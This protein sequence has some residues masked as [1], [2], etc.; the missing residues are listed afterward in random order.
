MLLSGLANE[1]VHRVLAECYILLLGGRIGR[2][3]RHRLF[4]ILLG[5]SVVVAPLFGFQ[6]ADGRPLLTRDTAGR[7]SSV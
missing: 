3:E 1:Y 5:G 2:V 4:V 6:P 7:P